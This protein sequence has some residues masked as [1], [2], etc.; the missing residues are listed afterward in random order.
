M[1]HRIRGVN[2]A[3]AWRER[4]YS[5]PGRSQGRSAQEKSLRSK[6]CPEKSAEGIVAGAASGE[7][8]NS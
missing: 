3:D 8:P 5:Y 6:A 7:G 1:L 2:A 4:T